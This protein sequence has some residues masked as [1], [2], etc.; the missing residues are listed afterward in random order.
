[1]HSSRVQYILLKFLTIFCHVILNDEK[2]K[3]SLTKSIHLKKYMIN[4][5]IKLSK[6]GK[7]WK[8]LFDYSNA[9]NVMSLLI[10]QTLSMIFNIYLLTSKTYCYV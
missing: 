5:S 2:I 7:E 10:V 6:L 8:L 4:Y 3:N 1:M 9:K